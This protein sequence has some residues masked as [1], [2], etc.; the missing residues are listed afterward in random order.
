MVAAPPRRS[1]PACGKRSFPA[2]WSWSRW[3]PDR[4]WIS[5]AS[6]SSA[7]TGIWSSIRSSPTTRRS[8]SCA[9]AAS[10]RSLVTNRDHERASAAVAAATG[11]Q[12][13][14]ERA[15]RAAARARGRPH[16]RART[17]SCYGWTVLGLDGFKTPARSRWATGAPQRGDRRRRAVGNARRRADLMPDAEARRSGPR[18]AVGCARCARAASGASARR[19][20][21]VRLRQRAR[22][23]RRDARRPRRRARG[24]AS[25]STSC[26]SGA[27]PAIRAVRRRNAP[28]SAGCSA[29]EKLG[30]AVGSLRARRALLPVPLAHRARKSCSS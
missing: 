30:Y 2:C 19:R 23:D 15:R 20:R 21:R 8:P 25:T 4:A 24:A 5:T 10:P 13:H 3:Q 22:G 11:A 27:L 17:T 18:G 28:R 29:R 1:A 9:S 26:R 14:R 12:R 6:S 16:G 7:R